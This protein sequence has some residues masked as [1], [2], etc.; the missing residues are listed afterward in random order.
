MTATF[1]NIFVEPAIEKEGDVFVPPMFRRKYKNVMRGTTVKCGPLSN[2][3]EN[4]TILFSKWQDN[5]VE[6][7]GK[8]LLLI[9]PQHI[10]A[11]A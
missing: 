10:F 8:Q 11:I 4:E 2:V 1:D 3:A 9:K 5:F 7:D 6:I